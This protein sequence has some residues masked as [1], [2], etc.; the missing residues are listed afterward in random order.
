MK[1]D[2]VSER[3]IGDV[4]A[5]NVLS[6]FGRSPTGDVTM[7][8]IDCDDEFPFVTETVFPEDS[9][10]F[11]RRRLNVLFKELDE[12]VPAGGRSVIEDPTRQLTVKNASGYRLRSPDFPYAL[13]DKKDRPG[14]RKLV[15]AGELKHG[16]EWD[17]EFQTRCA[18]PEAQNEIRFATLHSRKT[19]EWAGKVQYE[20]GVG[21][22]IPGLFSAE[23]KLFF[24][25]QSKNICEV[26]HKFEF[27]RA[28]DLAL[29]MG[30]ADGDA[31]ELALALSSVIYGAFAGSR[32]V[33]LSGFD[34]ST[35]D[36]VFAA[37]ILK[38]DGE[39][40]GLPSG[41]TSVLG[42]TLTVRAQDVCWKRNLIRPSVLIKIA[43]D[44]EGKATHAEV[45]LRWCS[46]YGIDNR[47]PQ[48]LNDVLWNSG[49]VYVS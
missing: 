43:A 4:N 25:D 5:I 45:L 27:A 37:L 3:T 8:G 34:L 18:A 49:R 24:T 20:V 31:A 6:C 23:Q 35:D 14:W 7:P 26:R 16:F 21:Y 1:W 39:G 17:Y 28:T 9:M 32:V 30:I 13:V 47:L 44:A 42:K 33:K 10:A 12:F 2:D 11:T 48:I 36:R 19:A 15:K 40:F 41:L 29:Q 46:E 38:G 22:R